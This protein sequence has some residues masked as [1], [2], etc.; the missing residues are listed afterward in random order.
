MKRTSKPVC[1]YTGWYWEFITMIIA[2]LLLLFFC[3]SSSQ[4]LKA[5][6][7]LG[8]RTMTSISI[9]NSWRPFVCIILGN[10]SSIFQTL[11]QYQPRWRVSRQPHWTA[12]G[13]TPWFACILYSCNCKYRKIQVPIFPRAPLNVL[14]KNWDVGCLSAGGRQIGRTGAIKKSLM[15]SEIAFHLDCHPL[16]CCLLVPKNPETIYGTL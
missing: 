11:M 15:W 7:W 6:D 8:T 5:L 10:R 1:T 12:T 13:Y 16:C 4:I 3:R 9:V 2:L 14:F